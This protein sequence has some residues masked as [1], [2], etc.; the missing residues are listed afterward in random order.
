MFPTAGYFRSTNCPFFVHG[1]CHRPYCHFRHSKPGLKTSK[2]KPSPLKTNN[3]GHHN[4]HK[5]KESSEHNS[6]GPSENENKLAVSQAKTGDTQSPCD[7]NKHKTNALVIKSILKR[8]TDEDKEGST[9]GNSV[10]CADARSTEGR[11]S[12]AKGNRTD[13]FDGDDCDEPVT[14]LTDEEKQIIGFISQPSRGNDFSGDKSSG[15]NKIHVTPSLEDACGNTLNSNRDLLIS[16]LAKGEGVK[17]IDTSVVRN[18]PDVG[19]KEDATRDEETNEKKLDFQPVEVDCSAREDPIVTCCDAM[20]ITEEKLSKDSGQECAGQTN[21]D[22]ANNEEVDRPL[23]KKRKSVQLKTAMMDQ[24]SKKRKS[25][26]LLCVTDCSSTNVGATS[27]KEGS[28]FNKLVGNKDALKGESTLNKFLE[29]SSKLWDKDNDPSVTINDVTDKEAGTFSPLKKQSFGQ[30]CDAGSLKSPDKDSGAKKKVNIAEAEIN[31]FGSAKKATSKSKK[32]EKDK[33]KEKILSAKST[34]ANNL[35]TRGKAKLKDLRGKFVKGITILGSNDRDAFSSA[36]K[37]SEPSFEEDSHLK[38]IW[39][40]FEPKTDSG[41]VEAD[42]M[43]TTRNQTV[44]ISVK[45]E[46]Q[47]PVT[48]VEKKP[49]LVNALGLGKKQRIA[50]T[51]NHLPRRLSSN[52]QPIRRYPKT[53]AATLKKDESVT[54]TSVESS[55]NNS[56]SYKPAKQRIAHVAKTRA[57]SGSLPRPRIPLEYGSKVPQNQ[58]QRYLDRIIDEYLRLCPTQK[59]AFEKALEEEKALYE[60]STRRQVYLNLCVNAIKK[61]RDMKPEDIAAFSPPKSET[62]G[63]VAVTK[64]LLPSGAV[65]ISSK[66]PVKQAQTVMTASGDLTEEVMYDFFLKYLMTEEDLVDNGYPRSCPNSPGKA[67]FKMKKEQPS[68]DPTRRTC[69]R[70]GKPFVVLDDGEYVTKEEC[71]YHAGRLFRKRGEQITSY[72]C[73][74]GDAGSPGC[75]VGKVHVSD[76]MYDTDGFMTTIVSPLADQR[77]KIFAMDCEMSYTTAGLELTRIS[78]VNWNLEVVYDTFVMPERTIVDYNTRFSG[79]TEESLRGVTTTIREVQAVLLS[80]IHKDTVLVGHSLESDLKATKLIHSK[81]V[82][83]SVVF[84]H[85]LGAPYKRALRNLMADHL[86]KIIQD[87]VDGHDSFEDAKACLELMRWKVKEDMKKTR[88]KSPRL[89]LG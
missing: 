30:N 18:V 87:S 42:P 39:D 89:S 79:V 1:L 54:S 21:D 24:K 35:E 68:R 4:A 80:M 81:V 44:G 66:S 88:H 40:D 55:V 38:R 8:P 11:S 32:K 70:C 2:G 49:L 7:E 67:V 20:E 27:E 62:E 83:T 15:A 61:L 5:K 33:S 47:T 29:S 14:S 65:V 26:Q 50:H 6:E 34:K 25:Q 17:D 36:C 46:S 63:Q 77:K 78:V 71:T 73:C 85:R 45:K 56:L 28:K 74:Q 51:A 52:V 76:K 16:T 37:Y 41:E 84:P 82:D 3:A 60:R 86:K 12:V 64:T 10:N 43:L 59:E 48:D 58:R 13:E 69:Q 9:S 23:P 22:H 31:F 53:L 19:N 57:P 72:S 75:C